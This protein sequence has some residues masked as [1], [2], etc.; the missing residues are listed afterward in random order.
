MLESLRQ[1]WCRHAAQADRYLADFDGI[2]VT[3][4][5]NAACECCWVSPIRAVDQPG[6]F[7]LLATC[8]WSHA[9]A[10]AGRQVS[11][12]CRRGRYLAV[13][14]ADGFWLQV[15]TDHCARQRTD[16]VRC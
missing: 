4:K 5:G 13:H 14:G 1:L 2:A 10:V 8:S 16:A 6:G 3:D 7:F 9:Q 12:W 11:G 15:K